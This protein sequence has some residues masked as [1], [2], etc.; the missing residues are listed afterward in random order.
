MPRHCRFQASGIPKAKLSYVQ[1]MSF[2]MIQGSPS[3]RTQIRSAHL[4]C[5]RLDSASA[6]LSGFSACMS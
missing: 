4:S 6:V 1:P 5:T 2:G 3:W